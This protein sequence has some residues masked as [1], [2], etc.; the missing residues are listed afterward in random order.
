MLTCETLCVCL[1]SIDE[2]WNLSVCK[3]LCLFLS[4]I[5][6]LRNNYVSIFRLFTVGE[7]RNMPTYELINTVS[8]SLNYR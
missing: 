7:L 8:L 6:E 4:A 1:S 3:T 2:L 5:C